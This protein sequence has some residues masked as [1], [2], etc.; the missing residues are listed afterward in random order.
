MNIKKTAIATLTLA[1][2][3]A[4]PAFAQTN[5]QRIRHA[6]TAAEN[7]YAAAA[8]DWSAPARNPNVVVYG[9]TVVGQDPDVN[10]R[11][12]L[13]RDPGSFNQ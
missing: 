10:I 2:L 3:V 11:L 5:T 9:N 7:S 8:T 4:S 12:Q 6:N 13:L 1:T